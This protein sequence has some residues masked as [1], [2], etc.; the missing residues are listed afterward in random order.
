MAGIPLPEPS[1]Y[2][3]L[4]RNIDEE[5]LPDHG[6]DD[7]IDPFANPDASGAPLAFD[8]LIEVTSSD[9]TGPLAPPATEAAEVDLAA[10]L[11]FS[12]T[13]LES[14]LPQV[15]A[16]AYDLGMDGIEPFDMAGFGQVAEVE[17]KTPFAQ[18]MPFAEP[19]PQPAVADL[20]F[21]AELGDIVPFAFDDGDSH[22]ADSA[23]VD[24]T[25]LDVAPEPMISRRRRWLNRSR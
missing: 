5:T 20:P 15:D 23:S 13:D 25:E 16:A 3:Q 9:G 24:F 7:E 12:R 19:A 17:P 8:E 10:E 1:G 11:D 2:T 4:L 21:V 14:A 18:P 22:G 6:V